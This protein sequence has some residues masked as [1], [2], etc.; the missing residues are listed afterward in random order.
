MKKGRLIVLEGMSGVGKTTLA[1]NWV[2]TLTDREVPVIYLHG[3]LSDTPVGRRFK[4]EV[5]S[6]KLELTSTY[7]YLADLVQLTQ[8]QIQPMLKRGYVVIQD[9]YVDSII[10]F[11]RALT[12]MNGIIEDIKPVVDLYTEV[13]LL[14]RPEATI[15]CYASDK[16]IQNRLNSDDGAHHKYIKNPH[17]LRSVSEEFASLMDERIHAGDTVHTIKMDQVQHLS[18]MER[19][20]FDLCE[21]L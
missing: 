10:S 7:Y 4:E 20:I 2:K 12:K 11:H 15:W 13:G 8:S 5:R 3:A 1:R 19:F 14:A 9:R 6:R 17:L 18:F 21:T 16:V